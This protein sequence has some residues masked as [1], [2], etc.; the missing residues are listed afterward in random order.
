MLA[1][2]GWAWSFYD[3]S[4]W[5]WWHM[6]YLINVKQWVRNLSK[7]GTNS[8][9]FWQSFKNLHGQNIF[10]GWT[11]KVL[12]ESSNTRGLVHVQYWPKVAH[13]PAHF[14]RAR[15][16]RHLQYMNGRHARNTRVMKRVSNAVMTREC[17][18]DVMRMLR[19][20]HANATRMLC[21]CCANVVRM[22]RGCCADRC[23]AYVVQMRRAS[24]ARHS[25]SKCDSVKRVG[26]AHYTR[27][28]RCEKRAS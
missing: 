28:T 11:S 7:S 10:F 25:S 27:C 18:A 16:A 21:G 14:L 6:N 22:L 17:H 19:G 5:L 2:H 15:S 1:A 4:K 26:C 20:C 9:F 8:T 3:P 24:Y 23:C 13:G 12:A